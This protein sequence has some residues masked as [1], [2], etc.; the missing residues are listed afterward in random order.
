MENNLKRYNERLSS[1]EIPEAERTQ[2]RRAKEEA[3]RTL[4][5]LQSKNQFTN[6]IISLHEQMRDDPDIGKMIEAYKA[7][8]Q[9]KENPVSPKS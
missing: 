2:V 8:T 4:R 3:E 5:E 9:T 7:K 6:Q 1:K